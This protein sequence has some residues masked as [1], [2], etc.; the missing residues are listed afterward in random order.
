MGAYRLELP[1]RQREVFELV[2]MR[3]HS[4]VEVAKRLGISPATVRVLLLKARRAI[5]SRMLAA[6]PRLLEEYH[7]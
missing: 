4:P 1:R 3:G 5:R 7:S 2:D 6:H